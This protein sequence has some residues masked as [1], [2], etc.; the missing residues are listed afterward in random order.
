ML[1]F[2]W[3]HATPSTGEWGLLSQDLLETK[4]ELKREIRE[5]EEGQSQA[6]GETL[7][8]F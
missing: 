5:R 4:T 6:Q 2:I 8:L 3:W 7:L 1:P